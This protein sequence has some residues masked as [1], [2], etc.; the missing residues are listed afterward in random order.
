MSPVEQFALGAVGSLSVEVVSL[1]RS[2]GSGKPLAAKYRRPE[3][4][5]VRS[6]LVAFAG[7]MAWAT[8]VETS[9]LA[10][11]VGIVTP[12]I[13]DAINRRGPTAGL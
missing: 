8:H 12:F 7:L 6:L 3:Y 4:L 10:I 11:E 9:V 1:Y 13:V 2:L 5:V